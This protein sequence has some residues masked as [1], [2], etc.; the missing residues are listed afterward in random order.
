VRIARFAE[1]RLSSLAVRQTPLAIKEQ[2]VGLVLQ[3]RPEDFAA[4][5]RRIATTALAGSK[6]LINAD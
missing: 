6:H 4:I 1:S 2:S 3:H 5:E